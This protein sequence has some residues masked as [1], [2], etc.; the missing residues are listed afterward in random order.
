MQEGTLLT[1]EWIVRGE[2]CYW[3]AVVR[4]K[5]GT[6]SIM[7][8]YLDCPGI[9]RTK[10]SH[11]TFLIL[12]N[13]RMLSLKAKTMP[14]SYWIEKPD[15]PKVE[16]KVEDAPQKKKPRVITTED[17]SSSSDDDGEYEPSDEEDSSEESVNEEDDGLYSDDDEEEY[18]EW[19]EEEEEDDWDDD[20]AEEAEDDYDEDDEE[21]ER[22]RVDRTYQYLNTRTLKNGDFLW[23]APCRTN[24]KTE[25][26]STAQKQVTDDSRRYCD[27]SLWCAPCGKAHHRNY[28]TDPQKDELDDSVR[29]CSSHLW[30]APCRQGRPSTGFSAPQKREEDDTRRYCLRHSGY[31]HR[32]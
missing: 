19:D 5:Y 7:V 27:R 14:V 11:E 17:S 32:N 21:V 20:Q 10:G 4:Q 28:F 1:I 3:S 9:P 23:C 12:D 15:S 24:H 16:K 13:K 22:Q 18:D 8:K 29:Y 6:D 26:F 31:D 2:K 30:C 25:N